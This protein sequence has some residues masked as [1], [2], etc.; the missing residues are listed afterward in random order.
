MKKLIIILVLLTT[1][2]SAFAVPYTET[3]KTFLNKGSFIYFTGSLTEE[4]TNG[5]L[6]AAIPRSEINSMSSC[7]VSMDGTSNKGLTILM[8]NYNRTIILNDKIIKSITQD[9]SGNISI[10]LI[11]YTNATMNEKYLEKAYD[12]IFGDFSY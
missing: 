10:E 8:F 9:S 7:L 1:S 3:I 4:N 2:F 11:Q 6:F 12:R 5:E